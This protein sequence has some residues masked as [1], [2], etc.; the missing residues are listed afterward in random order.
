MHA[1]TYRPTPYIVLSSEV[2]QSSIPSTCHSKGAS[3]SKE[4]WLPLIVTLI[5][6]MDFAV[7]VI[8][9]RLFFCCIFINVFSS[10]NK[11]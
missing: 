5:A 3:S 7:H 6:C 8:I 2:V 1:N 11:K 10:F 9:Y 4:E